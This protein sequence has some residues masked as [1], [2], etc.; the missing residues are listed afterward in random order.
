M[1]NSYVKLQNEKWLSHFFAKIPKTGDSEP[2]Q[3]I[4]IRLTLGI[5]LLIYFCLPWGVD[6]SFVENII[7]FPSLIALTYY[8]LAV[9]ITVALVIN[10]RPSPIRRVCGILLDLTALSI[11]ML[12]AGEQSVFL[13]VLYLWVILGNGFRY[14]VNYLYIS[15]AVGLIG[16]T[17]AILN[18]EYWSHPQHEPFGFS[19]LFLL[20]I[21]PLYSAFLIKKLHVAIALSKQANEAKSRFL[22]NMSHELRT[23]L[24]GVIGIADL[25]AETQ[26]NKQQHDFVNIMKTSAHTLLSLIENVLDIAKIEAGKILISDKTF[27]LHQLLN[28]VI[29]M[30]KPM[31]NSKGLHINCYIDPALPFSVNGDLQHLRQVLINLIGN[32]IKFTDNGAVKLSALSIQHKSNQK[33]WIRFEVSDTGIGIPEEALQR[34][35]DDF[36]Q[37]SPDTL[38]KGGTGLGT[39]IAKELVELMGGEIGV[40]SEVGEGTLFWFEL[41]FTTN[42]PNE[43]TLS[44]SPMLILSTD[45]LHDLLKPVIN[46]WSVNYQHVDS[47]AKAFSALIR[48]AESQTP[49]QTVMIDQD[50]MHDIDPIQFANMIHGEPL[51]ANTA[52]ILL[53]PSDFSKQDPRLRHHFISIV[54]DVQIKPV[55]FNAIHAAQSNHAIQDEKVIPLAQH[56][57]SQSYAKSLNILIAEDN[58]VNQQVLEG[59]LRHAGHNVLLASSGEQALDLLSQQIDSIEMLILD[60]NM[61][62]YSGPE[63]IRAMRYMDTGHDIPII[64]LTAD[65]TPQAKQRCIEA[66][67]NEFLTKPIDSRSLLESIARLAQNTQDNAKTRKPAHQSSTASHQWCDPQ[68][69]IE[70]SQLGGGEAFLKLLFNGYKE[71]GTKHLQLIRQAAHNDYLTY[72]ESLHALKGSS[73]ELGANSVA[74]LCRQ[75]EAYKPFDIGSIQLLRLTEK[76]EHAFLQTL[77]EL[78]SALKAQMPSQK[79]D[80]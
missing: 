50:C 12:I 7:S 57:A 4:L 1:N 29:A 24:N 59:I 6:R 41:P 9:V 34:I 11:V 13:F 15:L 19:L 42:E 62:D 40:S 27:D 31:A 73:S 49:F 76:L 77:K 20:L 38:N 36:T 5:G 53:N 8:L 56:Y 26:L 30:Q 10:P 32:S 65:A 2:E 66:G 35:F 74:E 46:G 23:P 43:L 16:F 55:L 21:I 47:T 68:I 25:M 51:L 75:G 37:I 3:A 79:A 60:M 33:Q 18:G 39:T 44:E 52:L 72:R 70:L 78:E 14:G 63:V 67:A 58:L 28:S 54:Q 22:A 64:I 17:I 71:D 80:H 48:A 61:P 69:L 45:S